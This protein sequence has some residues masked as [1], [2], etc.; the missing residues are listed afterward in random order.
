MSDLSRKCPQCNDDMVYSCQAS[1]RHADRS[2]SLCRK[3]FQ[4]GERNPMFGRSVSGLD[5]YKKLPK[6]DL[7]GCVFNNWE[8]LNV[9]H[10]EEGGFWYWDVKCTNCGFTTKRTTNYIKKSRGCICC[11]L[12]SKGQSGL[13]KL[14]GS[15][16]DAAKQRDRCF[17]LTE[18]QFRTLTSSP[19]HYCGSQPGTKKWRYYKEDRSNWGTYVYNGVD[20]VNNA[21]G[22]TSENS[23]A[24]CEVCNRAKGCMDAAIW[25]EYVK[26]FAQNVLNGDVPCLR[27]N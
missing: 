23:V 7:T 18:E 20:R 17:E 6:K 15:Y 26:R 27:E 11:G 16:R 5:G 21:A 4:L 1:R 9:S 19:C 25:N 14:L 8:V 3:C 10:R 12:S 2:N 22:Y 24:C 13:N